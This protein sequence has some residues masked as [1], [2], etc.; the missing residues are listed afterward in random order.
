MGRQPKIAISSVGLMNENQIGS[1]ELLICSHSL[2]S[3]RVYMTV[4][5]LI[6]LSMD[7]RRIPPPINFHQYGI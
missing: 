1:S 7:F 3:R 5:M 2:G 4:F 6:Y